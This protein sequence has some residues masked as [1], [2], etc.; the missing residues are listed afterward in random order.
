MT[1][2]ALRDGE[3]EDAGLRTDGRAARG[4]PGP[5]TQRSGSVVSTNSKTISF[6]PSGRREQDK[7]QSGISLCLTFHTW[8]R[9]SRIA[10]SAE[11]QSGISLCLTFHD[12]PGGL[13]PLH[14]GDGAF[15]SGISLCLTFHAGDAGSGGSACEVSIRHQPVSDIPPRA[16]S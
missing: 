1:E 8:S 6:R 3:V 16:R 7:F 5:V 11:F 10:G 15:Q 2:C 14:G 4:M 13:L 12:D 9:C